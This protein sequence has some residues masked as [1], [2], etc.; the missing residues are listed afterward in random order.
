QYWEKAVAANGKLIAARIN[1]A[2]LMLEDMRKI[3]NAKDKKWQALEGDAR[4]HLS[5]ALGVDSDSI[6]AYTVYALVYMEGWKQ[7]KNRLDLAKLLLDEGKKRNEK[8]APLQNAY[9]LLYMHRGALSL[10]LQSFNAA[11]E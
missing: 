1:L 2:Q 9:G 6:A 11:V 5:N 10:A 3:G 4:I 8:F 7:N